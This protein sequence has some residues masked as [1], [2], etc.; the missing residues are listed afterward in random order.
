MY[1]QGLSGVNHDLESTP[2]EDDKEAQAVFLCQMEIA[3]HCRLLVP[4]GKVVSVGWLFDF[5]ANKMRFGVGG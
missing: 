1:W 4:P 5:V 2:A 3:N